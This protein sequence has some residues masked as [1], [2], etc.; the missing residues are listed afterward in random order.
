MALDSE[1]KW[2]N[3][4]YNKCHANWVGI[5]E[6]EVGNKCSKGLIP[7]QYRETGINGLDVLS[8]R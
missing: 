1:F 4:H 3:G 8:Q 2:K 7:H 6:V 5:K